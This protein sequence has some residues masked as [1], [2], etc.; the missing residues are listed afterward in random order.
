MYVVN[1]HIK[2]YWKLTLHKGIIRTIIFVKREKKKYM[3]NLRI[4]LTLGSFTVELDGPPKEVTEQF[5]NLKEN[6][7]GQMIDQL[8]PLASYTKQLET[9]PML[10]DETKSM[11][12]VNTPM[13]SITLQDLSYKL[14]PKS[15]AEWV[16]AY[17]YFINLE[18][19]PSFTR[20]EIISKYQ[21][22]GRK[23][24]NN[25]KNLSAS[26]TQAARKGW[27]SA[28]NTDEFIVTPDGQTKMQEIMTR[29]K[30]AVKIPRKRLDKKAEGSTSEWASYRILQVKFQALLT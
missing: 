29:T 16:L 22:S 9:T 4:K 14:L 12:H 6:G 7:L 21:E 28:R 2:I 25:I 15:E 30:P 8:T 23:N 27:I 13:T 18:G 24:E 19:Q 1:W 17:G 11:S 5:T 10:I 26:I 3:E 20:S